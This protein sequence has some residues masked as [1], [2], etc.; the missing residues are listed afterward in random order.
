M[1]DDELFELVRKNYVEVNQDYI[2]GQIK[3]ICKNC[4]NNPLNGGS[5]I[6]HCVLGQPIIY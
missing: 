2:V 5:G 4:P 6:C 1:T 3:N